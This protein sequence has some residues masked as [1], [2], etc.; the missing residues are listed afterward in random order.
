MGLEHGPGVAA[1]S[2]GGIDHHTRRDGC[3]ERGDLMNKNRLVVKGN[4]RRWC[5]SLIG[6]PP[7]GGC[8]RDFSPI[9]QTEAGGV[10]A[11]I[12]PTGRLPMSDACASVVSLGVVRRSSLS[13]LWCCA[14]LR[15]CAG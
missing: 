1:T 9:V 2:D 6:S 10:G 13:L 14:L 15:R 4:Q 7:V 11:S 5:N 12:L 8:R 3:E